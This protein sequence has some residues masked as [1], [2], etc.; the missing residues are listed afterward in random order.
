MRRDPAIQI[1]G[2]P[3]TED[4]L[5]KLKSVLDG[6]RGDAPVYLVLRN[7]AGERLVIQVGRENYV[8]PGLPLLE[9]MERLL[10]P[11][12]LLVNRMRSRWETD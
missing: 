1:D 11:D 5:F 12:R 4:L 8:S 9:E 10:G 2:A 6:H 7:Q 3:G